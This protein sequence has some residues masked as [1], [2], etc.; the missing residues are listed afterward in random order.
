MTGRAF[1]TACLVNLGFAWCAFGGTERANGTGTGDLRLVGKWEKTAT[2]FVGTGKQQFLES[3]FQLTGDVRIQARIT[4]KTLAHTAATFCINGNSHFGFDGAGKRLFV[5]GPVLRRADMFLKPAAAYITPGKPFLFEVQRSGDKLTFRIDGR[6]VHACKDPRRS[7]GYFAFRPWRNQMRIDDV[8]AEGERSVRP[9]P[10]PM[11]DLS[12]E[13]NRHVVIAAGTPEIYQGHPTT[14]LMA[15]GKTMWAV[16]TMNHG[17]PCGPMKKSLDGGMTWSDLLPIPDGWDACRNC[18][19]IYRLTD[20][21]GKER[22]TILCGGPRTMRQI[23]SEDDGETWTG[24]ID[25][26][27]KCVMAFCAVMPL[28]D[29]RHLGLFHKGPDG[30]DRSPLVVLQSI[31]DDGGLTWGTPK[32][33]AEVAGRDPC[34]PAMIRSPDGNQILCLMRDNKHADHSLMMT[35]DDE[36][37][38]WSKPVDTCWGLTGDRHQPGYAPDGRMVVPFRDQAPGSPTKGHFVAWVGTYDDAVNARAGQCRVKLLHSYAGGD[39]GYPGLEVLPDGTLVATTYIKY[40]PG[41][42]KHSVVSVRFK[43]A[44]IDGELKQLEEAAAL[45]KQDLFTGM[46]IPKIVVAPDGSLLAFAKCCTFLRRSGDQGKT[47]SPQENVNPEGGGNVVVDD[48][49]GHVLIVCPGKL[50]LWRSKDNGQTWSRE[51]ITLKPNLIG[52]G[53]PDS[54][55]VDLVASESG[56]TLHHGEHEGRLV[57]PGRIQPPNGDNAQECWQY[58]YNT[59][60]YSDDGGTTWQVGEPVQSGTG[61]G[62][63]AELSDG[64]IYYNSRCHMAVD[65]KRR[66]AWSHDGGRRWVDWETS[67]DLFEVGGPFYYK[68]GSKPSYG[69]NAGL[70]RIP[71]EATGGKDVLIYCAPDN[72]GAVEPHNGRVRLTLWT[73]TDRAGSWP[74]KRLIH[75]GISV[76]SSVTADE[77]G[78]VYVLYESGENK[79][80]EKITFARVDLDWLGVNP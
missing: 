65:H 55:P 73:S 9:V 57:M 31:S 58:N 27:F 2:G 48:T 72:P 74:V 35:T 16:W 39:C 19:S 11:V 60:I 70:V 30:A 47:W 12:Q 51:S 77:S 4:L 24:P 17:G 10:P 54:I 64:R 38:T 76:Y 59:S 56:I 34:E 1:G 13:K 7:F 22:L 15:D 49:T 78:N 42:D 21:Q 80:Y 23:I 25:L 50:C 46:R 61:E 43:M 45:A 62:T 40:A 8:T 18:P 79:L 67:E 37:E 14:C 41:E 53:T 71:P 6:Q 32:V 66:I 75:A 52:H 68:Y 69:C 44:D 36:G 3:D 28:K 20:R 5:E 26:G 29:G 63:L 33:V